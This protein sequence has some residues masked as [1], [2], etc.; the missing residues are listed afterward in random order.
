MFPTGFG[1][2]ENWG[3]CSCNDPIFG[4]TSACAAEWPFSGKYFSKRIP[5][6]QL[7]IFIR[8]HKIHTKDEEASVVFQMKQD[9]RD[10]TNDGAS[11]VCGI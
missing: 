2:L 7:N 1:F 3:T 9:S 11:K 10:T 6:S 8:I 5:S 4:G